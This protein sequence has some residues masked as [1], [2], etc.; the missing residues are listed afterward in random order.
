MREVFEPMK[1]GNAMFGTL[2][3]RRSALRRTDRQ[4]GLLDEFEDA[5]ERLW[6]TGGNEWTFGGSIPS[7]D[8][9]ETDKS[10]EVKLDVPGVSSK[11]IKIQL[12]G[13]LLT[14]RGERTEEQEKK[15]KKF[16]RVE[17]RFGSF[18]RSITLPCPVQ[19]D[20]VAAEYR[21]GVLS[22]TLPKTEERKSRKIAVKS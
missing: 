19:E 16:H 7:L 9:S 5:M 17:R 10:V 6:S 12:N 20:K 2:T 3:P 18:S 13:N 1:G 21:D 14:V 4:L 15:G 11:E 8:I 22:I